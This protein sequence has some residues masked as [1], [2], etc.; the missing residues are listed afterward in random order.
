MLPGE[1]GSLQAGFAE[2]G[3]LEMRFVQRLLLQVCPDEFSPL[4]VRLAQI[5]SREQNCRGSALFFSG[6]IPL[7][8]GE[9]AAQ[10][11]QWK[12]MQVYI[13]QIRTPQVQ[14]LAILLLVTA[15]S[16]TTPVLVCCQEPRDIGTTQFHPLEGI[17]ATCDVR[18]LRKT[19]GQLFLAL[20]PNL[21]F[22]T[23]GFQLGL[24]C[25]TFQGKCSE[26]PL[27]R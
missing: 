17:D 12:G 2:V 25:C 13:T 19:E 14:P 26:D 4:Q 21:W 1:E 6:L 3:S 22:S 7:F 9:A 18:D 20:R 24:P 8:A 11:R 16:W 5:G 15:R 23:P 27:L 10:T